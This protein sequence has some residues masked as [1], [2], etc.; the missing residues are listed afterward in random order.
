MRGCRESGALKDRDAGGHRPAGGGPCLHSCAVFLMLQK[1][2]A[3]FPRELGYLAGPSEHP[4]PGSQL[5]QLAPASSP[6]PNAT[7]G[8]QEVPPTT[9]CPGGC[10]T[11]LED[12][13]TQNPQDTRTVRAEAP[14]GEGVG[15][16]RK[17]PAHLLSTAQC[18]VDTCST[19]PGVGTPSPAGYRPPEAVAGDRVAA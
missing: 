2:C 11:K 19:R 1:Q 13:N 15:V 12:R 10:R 14:G 9:A 5:G 7:W 6:L 4:S 8:H 18:I 16:G 3:D 17:P